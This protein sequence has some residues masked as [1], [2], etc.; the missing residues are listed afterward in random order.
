MFAFVDEV[1]DCDLWWWV[2]EGRRRVL[3]DQR[4]S[5]RGSGKIEFI[6]GEVQELLD[7]LF[8]KALEFSGRV[9]DDEVVQGT[10]SGVVLWGGL[11]RFHEG[12]S[13]VSVKHRVEEGLLETF[14]E[15]A[16]HL[17]KVG[18]TNSFCTLDFDIKVGDG[19]S[20]NYKVQ[21]VKDCE[22][23]HAKFEFSCGFRSH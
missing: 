16:N 6:Y 13:G 18:N 9:V 23:G 4:T 14:V 1:V 2:S 19:E 11:F 22:G 15:V 21:L 8:V 3:H 12:H 17:S 20:L 7:R 10:G 5:I